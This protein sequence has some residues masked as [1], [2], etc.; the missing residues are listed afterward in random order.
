MK[1]KTDIVENIPKV[2]DVVVYNPPYYKG[3]KLLSIT[4]FTKAGC[5]VGYYL[6]NKDYKHIVKTDFFITNINTNE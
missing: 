3:I 2:G 6:D 1:V 5:P 4:E